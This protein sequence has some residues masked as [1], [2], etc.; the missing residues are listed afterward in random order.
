MLCLPVRKNLRVIVLLTQLLFILFG[1]I[2]LEYTIKAAMWLKWFWKKELPL[3]EVITIRVMMCVLFPLNIMR[4][5]LQKLGV[6]WPCIYSSK[7]IKE[8]RSSVETADL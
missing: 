7:A 8:K 6:G 5:P 2:P 1:L 3:V 4:R